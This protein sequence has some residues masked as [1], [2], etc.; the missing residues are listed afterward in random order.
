MKITIAELIKEVNRLKLNCTTCLSS[1]MKRIENESFTTLL[2]SGTSAENFIYYER[3][4]IF[5]NKLMLQLKEA[6]AGTLLMDE[7]K[8]N[9]QED[10]NKLTNELTSAYVAPW[11]THSTNPFDSIVACQKA[12]AMAYHLEYLKGL[13]EALNQNYLTC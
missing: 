10:I 2:E 9:I 12:R 6:E 4:Y 8:Q 3:N 5:F 13:L 11:L 7:L 1:Y